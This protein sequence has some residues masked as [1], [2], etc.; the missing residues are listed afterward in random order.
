MLQALVTHCE[1][2]IDKFAVLLLAISTGELKELQTYFKENSAALAL[3]PM[4][5]DD[6]AQ[7]VNRQRRL[8]DEKSSIEAR[9]EPLQLMFKT[10]EKV[11]FLVL[12]FLVA[13]P[14]PVTVRD[15]PPPP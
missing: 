2:W 3:T 9:F 11:R 1:Q 7:V 13:R 6:L 4:N 5:L 14:R 15:Q 12:A 8:V 10:L